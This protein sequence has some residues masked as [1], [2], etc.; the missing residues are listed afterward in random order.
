MKRSNAAAWDDIP[1]VPVRRRHEPIDYQG[2]PLY[3]ASAPAPLGP[4]PLIDPGIWQDV[5]A[6]SRE[7]AW[8]DN[9]PHRQATYL[10]GPGSAGKSLFGQQ[11]ATC[12]ALGRPFLGIDT[13]G[14]AALYLTCEDDAD[15][16]HRRQAAIC[17]ALRVRPADL[18]G[19]LHLVSL[20]GEIGTEL[21]TV[22]DGGRLDLTDRFRALEAGAIAIDAKLIV[23]D[24]V[25]HLFGGNENARH[26][27]A[28]FVSL[29][30]R[31]AMRIDGAALLIGHPNKAG[32][33]FSGSTAWENQVRSRLFMEVPADSHDRDVRVL[34]RQKSNYAR[35]GEATTFRWLDWAFVRDDDLPIDQRVELA[36]NAQ[37]ASDNAVFL[38]CLDERNRQE[39]AVSESPASRTY[40]PKTFAEMAESDRIGRA[41]LEAAMDRLFRI[42]A[43]ER[44][45]VHR[46]CAEGK[47]RFGVRRPPADLSADHPLTGSADVPL[48]T[49]RPPPAH[50]PYTTYIS[51]A[52]SEAAAPNPDDIDWGDEA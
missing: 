26:E 31:L 44:G 19:K 32:D 2:F 33:N 48:T 12:H 41:R 52:A 4:L 11:L 38:R 50:T 28:A 7:W 42:G 49:R 13:R 21:F 14:G 25:A 37:A 10:T 34:S 29:L 6:P 3:P 1:D 17:R 8:T 18:S 15:E 46:D 23:L 45:F 51:G 27:V 40:A 9:I 36:A 22:Q 30:N 24:N 39:R 43:I 47:D 35:K 16:L 20:A 5:D